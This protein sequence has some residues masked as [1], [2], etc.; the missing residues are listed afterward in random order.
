MRR[1]SILI[2]EL[3]FLLS[4]AS[5]V[6]AW[7]V[8]GAPPTGFP[9]IQAAI[10]YPAVSDGDTIT[11]IGNPATPIVYSGPGFYNIDFKGKNLTVQTGDATETY[12]PRSAII[13]CQNM[14]RAFIFK[15]GE[16]ISP[17]FTF[18]RGFIIINGYAQDTSWPRE[19]NDNPSGY[20]GAIYIKDSTP[21]ITN[22]EIYNCTAD[23]GGG[24]IFCDENG[25]AQI[26]DCDI[27][28]NTASYNYAG[29]GFY[30]YIDINDVNALDVNDLHQYGGGIYAWNSSPHIIKCYIQYNEAV[31]SGGGIA[32][33]SSD[34]L[35]RDCII[36]E[37]SAW[38]NDDRIDQHGGGIYIKDCKGPGPR[39]DRGT[40]IRNSARKSGGGIAVIDSNSQ[41][42]GMATTVPPQPIE[43]YDNHC[44]ARAGG[45]YIQGNP[46]GDPNVD[47][48]KSNCII[49]TC[50]IAKN[51]GYLSGGVS[52]SYGSVVYI[53]NCNIAYNA[54]AWTNLPGGLECY[55]GVANV[56][57]TNIWGNIGV[58]VSKVGPAALQVCGDGEHP[59]PVGDLNRDCH[60]DFR[61]FA[62]M[63]L[64]WLECT[65]PECEPLPTP[66]DSDK[67][68]IPDLEDN[69]PFAYNPDQND[70]DYAGCPCTEGM[71]QG[72]NFCI[73]IHEHNG[74]G[75][76]F[77]A[78]DYCASQGKRLCTKEE[79]IMACDLK[80]N[81]FW[82]EQ[83]QNEEWRHDDGSCTSSYKPR[84]DYIGCDHPVYDCQHESLD[85]SYRCCLDSDSCGDGIG[86]ACDNCPDVY[87]PS[88][89]DS[90]GDGIGDACDIDGPESFAVNLNYLAT[91]AKNWLQ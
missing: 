4:L 56:T 23:A 69:C 54:A 25:N 70:G 45:I 60:V 76:W 28:I 80:L 3:V 17:P 55:D 86:D 10:D 5:T 74:D 50:N 51:L 67:D 57:N 38:V 22:C 58:Q 61:D 83:G 63:A 84:V 30:Q 6:H 13:D 46:H 43:I 14:G 36:Q 75:T 12:I 42:L 16:G 18:V 31:G 49:K 15:S 9:T 7:I 59:Y 77:E 41:I 64:N 72:N 79:Y 19:P 68:G 52:S 85:R 66:K 47:P 32:C 21:V 26:S 81:I 73:D 27:G 33:V 65:A 24:A 29:W 2:L 8:P 34:A 78:Y 37:N 44:L 88:Q 20:G 35:I 48:N 1:K 53:D 90:D 91:I 39:I 87:N 62:M 11:V 82:D 89:A 71:E 40:I